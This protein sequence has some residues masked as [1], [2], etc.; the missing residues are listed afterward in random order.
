VLIY[1]TQLSP[2]DGPH[3]IDV[4]NPTMTTTTTDDDDDDDDDRK[5]RQFAFCIVRFKTSSVVVFVNDQLG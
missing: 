3:R 5:Q 4:V 2:N 1:N